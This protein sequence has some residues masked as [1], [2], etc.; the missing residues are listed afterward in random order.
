[1]YDPPM[2]LLSEKLSHAVRFETAVPFREVEL[3]VLVIAREYD[4]LR[5]WAVHIA[6]ARR[7]GVNEDVI[8]AIKY[9]QAPE[10][11]DENDTLYF[12]YVQQLIRQHRV[13]EGVFNP[14]REKLGDRGIVDLTELIG[15]FSGLAMVMNGF[16]VEPPED[17]DLL[18]PL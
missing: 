3:V 18:L 2:A 5:E 16:E 1:M 9:K 6:Q 11:L 15:H 10:G 12:R 8:Q 13:E 14:M 4:C 7:A 17:P